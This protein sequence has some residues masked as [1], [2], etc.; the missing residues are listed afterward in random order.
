[1]SR[2]LQ[3]VPRIGLAIDRWDPAGGGAEALLAEL[4]S[5]LDGAGWDVRIVARACAGAPEHPLHRVRPLGLTRAARERSLARRLVERAEREDCGLTL[6]IRHLERVDLYW[7][8]GGS[9]RASLAAR[10]ESQGRDPSAA[11][12]GRQRVLCEL[13]RT[14]LEGG[15]AR[16][17]VCVSELVR[18]ELADAYPA[19]RDRLVT[20]A[21]GVDGE[22]FHPCERERAGRELRE[23]LGVDATTPLVVMAARH[24]ELKGVVPLVD[25]LRR[26]DGE[27]WVLL[28]AGVRRVDA[29]RR[30]LR[31]R[32]PADRTRVAAHEG[33]VALAS[34]AD[35][36]ALPTW[37]DPCSL[38]VLEA[39]SAGTPVVTTA[40]NGAA[41]AIGSEEVGSVLDTP[42]DVDGLERELARWLARI[43]DGGVDR[44]AVRASVA[45][46]SRSAQLAALEA[47]AR[48]LVLAEGREA[49]RG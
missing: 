2:L 9:H 3:R 42:A 37:R 46:R 7:P 30:W 40:R 22:R 47:L 12:R 24:P 41:E 5:H 36:C 27:P 26:L 15:G 38:V 6:G 18:A 29:W 43:R 32:L 20:I 35:L 4:A 34:A 8:H 17:V 48:E 13:E 25:A 49:P 33:S 45:E 19:C 1:V 44:D 10:R 16:R 31:G 39:L 28:L 14:L 21:N 11:P 23:R